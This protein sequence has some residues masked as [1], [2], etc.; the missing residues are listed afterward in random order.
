ML[1]QMVVRVRNTNGKDYSMPGLF[2]VGVRVSS[3]LKNERAWRMG[4]D[5]FE[6]AWPE[7][8]QLEREVRFEWPDDLVVQWWG[9]RL[10]GLSIWCRSGALCNSRQVSNLFVRF[11]R[12][13]LC[14]SSPFRPFSTTPRG[15]LC[16]DFNQP[17][18][19]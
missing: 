15:L 11:G 3:D 18:P 9:V 13:Q 4:A 16:F 7:H 6:R 8:A 1:V 12:T 2:Q 17:F 14:F 19:L 10:V 5:P